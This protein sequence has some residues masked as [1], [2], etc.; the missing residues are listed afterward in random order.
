M[1]LSHPETITSSPTSA[2]H[3]RPWKSHLP[4]DGSLGTAALEQVWGPR[5]GADSGED[6]HH[7]Y[8]DLGKMLKDTNKWRNSV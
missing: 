4:R 1:H 8:H 2:P 7:G 6:G 3:T 5:E